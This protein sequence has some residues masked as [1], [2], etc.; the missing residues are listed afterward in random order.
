MSKYFFRNHHGGGL[1][2][3]LGKTE[4]GCYVTVTNKSDHNE[5]NEKGSSEVI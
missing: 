2:K 4:L 3:H 1:C 5:T